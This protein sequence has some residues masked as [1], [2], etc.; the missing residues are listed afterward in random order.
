MGSHRL[1]C[2]GTLA[3]SSSAVT[4]RVP[5]HT[6]SRRGRQLIVRQGKCVVK[7]IVS[8]SGDLV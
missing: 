4:L 1:D 6:S 2:A 5:R 3:P 8:D 7:V